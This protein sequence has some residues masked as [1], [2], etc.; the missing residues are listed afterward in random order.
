MRLYTL[1]GVLVIVYYC[2]FIEGTYLIVFL[3]F[4]SELSWNYG[5]VFSLSGLSGSFL[6]FNKALIFKPD[7]VMC[8]FV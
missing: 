7:S 2:Y 3:H 6:F 4:F 8:V 1:V 5:Q